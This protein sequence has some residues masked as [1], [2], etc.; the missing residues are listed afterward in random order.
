[1][2]ETIFKSFFETKKSTK[3]WLFLPLSL[4]LHGLV[5]GAVLMVPLMTA[6][7]GMPDLKIQNV[8][9]V[10]PPTSPSAPP[11]AARART[12]SRGSKKKIEKKKESKPIS[13][14]R[15]VAPVEVPSDIIEE[16]IEDWGIDGGMEGGVPGGV[17]GGVP[18]GIIGSLVAGPDASDTSVQRLTTF[19]K[20]KLLK[21]VQPQYPPTCLRAHLQGTVIVEAVTDI[22]GRVIKVRIISGH[23]LFKNAAIEAVQKWVYEPYIING[24]PK[25]VV[26]TVSVHFRLGGVN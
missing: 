20:P 26:F 9:M 11:A 19:Q 12:S 16:S 4:L 22:Y 3:K 17:E 24:I 25:P 5:I 6:D 14:S 13:A 21:K 1:M 8:L 10:A 15:F 23:P 2:N 18:G 7:T